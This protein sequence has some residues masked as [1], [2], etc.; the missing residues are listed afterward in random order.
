[1]V[2]TALG[3]AGQER[4]FDQERQEMFLVMGGEVADPR[5][6]HFVD[7]GRL[8]VRGVFGTYEEAMKAWRAAAQET[9]DNAFVKYMI[10]RLR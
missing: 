1:M 8:D 10:I 2:L 6:A 7:L 3:M 9:V 5:G 4:E